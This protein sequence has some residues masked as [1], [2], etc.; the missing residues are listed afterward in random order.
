VE[1]L[2]YRPALLAQASVRFAH[3]ASG[4]SHLARHAAII[5]APDRRGMV[6]WEEGAAA[7]L[8]QRDLNLPAAPQA[9]FAELGEPFTDARLM[10]SLENEFAEWL[11]RQ[12]RLTIRSNEA[13]G[14][15]AG[16]D[17]A[18]EEFQR[19]LGEAA[20][21]GRQE[22]AEKLVRTF[23]RKLE[24]LEERLEREKHELREDESEHSHRK[25]EEALSHG[26]TLFGIFSKR[27]RSLSKSLT[28]RRL[29]AKAA[30][31]VEESRDAVE[32]LQKEIGELEEEKA[33]ALKELTMRWDQL[34]TQVQEL[35]VVP[36]K[37]DI[38]VE[39][40]GVLWRP[41]YV[42]VAGGRQLELAGY[43]RAADK[44]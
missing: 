12:A 32:A 25:Q 44:S 28:K 42:V 31:E 39:L 11:Y 7:P 30:A 29:T 24:T 21:R 19:R 36:L 8:E 38:A 1:G 26:E 33:G 16:P 41:Y 35:E 15:F 23:D 40:F 14:V 27:R 6:A 13:L 18:P 3:S 5:E 37:K 4:V 2:I 10:A 9:L 22:E 20:T 34:A 17:D 43:E